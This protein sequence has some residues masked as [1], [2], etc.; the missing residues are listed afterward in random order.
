MTDP[1]LRLF[2]DGGDIEYLNGRITLSAGL[3][4]A[5]FNSLFGGNERDPG[6]EGDDPLEWWG[7]KTESLEVRKLR[8][9][10]QHLIETLP[11]VP[12]NLRRLE[13]A[14]GIDLGWFVTDGPASFV[15]VVASQPA[16]N[17][18]RV[19]IGILIDDEL[20]KFSFT[21]Q[22]SEQAT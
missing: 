14:A 19:D 1:L 2:N 21:A 20:F 15:Q 11:L 18:V 9:Q 4:T 6:L 22:P 3:E 13:D 5:A 10:F 12:A 17:R 16:I 7:N 8:S